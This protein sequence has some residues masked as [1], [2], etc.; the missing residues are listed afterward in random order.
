MRVALAVPRVL[1]DWRANLPTMQQMITTAAHAGAQLV[2]F[3][4]AAVTGFVN[5]GDPVAD[6]ALGQT[7]P[8]PSD[9]RTRSGGT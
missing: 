8:W 2:V 4:E 7:I 5:T 6:L 1:A 3:S 9:H